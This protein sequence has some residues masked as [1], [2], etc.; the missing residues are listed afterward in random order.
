LH[1][2]E[3]QQIC[4]IKT[5]EHFFFILIVVLGFVFCTKIPALPSERFK[6]LLRPVQSFCFE[7]TSR[8]VGKNYRVESI[9]CR[10]VLYADLVG[11]DQAPHTPQAGCWAGPT[12]SLLIFCF[13]IFC[14]S[15]L[16]VLCCLFSFLKHFLN[17]NIC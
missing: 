11:T 3:N 13:F 14:F 4:I 9:Y 10:G 17:L 2:W 6:C 8:Q 15:F 7:L 5:F 12:F 16:F 1:T